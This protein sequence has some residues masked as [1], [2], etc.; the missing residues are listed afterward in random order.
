M[1][2]SRFR[3]ARAQSDGHELASMADRRDES[4]LI[5]RAACGSSRLS[6]HSTQLLK[7]LGGAGSRLCLRAVRL[8]N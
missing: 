2:H 3:A 6:Y 1:V 5:A 4:P 8:P 7:S